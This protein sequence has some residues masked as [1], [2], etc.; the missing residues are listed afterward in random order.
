M[1]LVKRGRDLSWLEAAVSSK[2]GEGEP[3]ILVTPPMTAGEAVAIGSAF[4]NSPPSKVAVIGYAETGV[5]MTG[6]AAELAIS[7]FSSACFIN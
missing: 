2:D 7:E 6:V 3:D 5:F 4:G 1:A